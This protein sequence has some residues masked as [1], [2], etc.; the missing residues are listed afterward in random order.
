MWHEPQSGLLVVAGGPRGGF[1]GGRGHTV[2]PHHQ[3]EQWHAPRAIQH[4]TAHLG[5]H[6]GHLARPQLTDAARVE[7]VLVTKR[8]IIE[9]IFDGADA[10]GG[11]DLG[12][13]RAD[14][15]HVLH[16]GM[17]FEHLAISLTGEQIVRVQLTRQHPRSDADGAPGGGNGQN[18]SR[19]RNWNC[20]PGSVLLMPPSG[21]PNAASGWPVVRLPYTPFRPTTL[22]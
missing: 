17:Q 9:E 10:L 8:Q 16:R 22:L 20:R 21:V 18:P 3:L 12:D 19:T 6:A 5:D 2:L 14:S 4:G 7:A 11:K 1:Y 15:L 13:A